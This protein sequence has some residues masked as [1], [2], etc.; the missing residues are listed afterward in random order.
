[1]KKVYLILQNGRIFEGRAF[2]ADGQVC[3]ELVFSTG[4]TGYL[5][6]L[7]DPSYY[8]QILVQT[9]PL[10]GN[11]GLVPEEFESPDTHLA[12]YVVRECCDA[13]SNYRCKGRL[14][15]WLKERGVVGI[16]GVDTR[17]LTAIIREYGSMKA[18]IT[19]TPPAENSLPDELTVYSVREAS[20]NAVAT[21]SC[22]KQEVFAPSNAKLKVAL[23][24]FGAKKSLILS[25]LENGCSVTL[26]P[27]N[28]PASEVLSGG[29][30]GVVLSGGP[31]NPEDDPQVIIEIRKLISR[32]PILATGLGFQ[33]LAL[34]VGA[35]TSKLKCGHRGSNQPVRDLSLDICCTTY[36][37]H[38]YTVDAATLPPY[39]RVS[40]VN[41]NDGSVEGI[42]YPAHRAIS[43]QFDPEMDGP[44]NHRR[45]FDEFVAMMTNTEKGE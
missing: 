20:K 28:T 4:V 41:V 45:L 37:N 26:L 29:Y 13:P 44:K 12:G 1:M 25:L 9:F 16:C 3:G 2:G 6:S 23:Y 18:I 21:V 8:G 33:L 27:Y 38:G 5:Q 36:Q 34:S 17:A 42:D 43:V 10:I 31:G 39:A 24:D 22:K 35:S 19:D 40:F 11:Y 30:D 15:E 14:D 7:T 32:L